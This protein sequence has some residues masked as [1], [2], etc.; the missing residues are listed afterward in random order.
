MACRC[1]V[2]T[3]TVTS[4]GVHAHRGVY[5]CTHVVTCIKTIATGCEKEP[6]RSLRVTF[7]PSKWNGRFEKCLVSPLRWAKSAIFGVQRTTN[8]RKPFSNS[9]WNDQRTQIA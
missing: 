4:V 6:G 9:V 5:T 2:A 1:I 7:P 8:S 3:V